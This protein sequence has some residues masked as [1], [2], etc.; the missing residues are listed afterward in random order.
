MSKQSV[1]PLKL[2]FL[3]KIRGIQRTG[4][5]CTYAATQPTRQNATSWHVAVSVPNPYSRNTFQKVPFRTNVAQAVIKWQS[6]GVRFGTRVGH[7][8]QSLHR[9]KPGSTSNTTW[10]LPSTL[11]SIYYSLSII[12]LNSVLLSRRSWERCQSF[13][14]NKYVNIRLQASGT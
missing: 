7:L 5:N 10:P 4:H 6:G 9:L 2:C 13:A 1:I 11:F 14:D 8:P 3:C 12:I